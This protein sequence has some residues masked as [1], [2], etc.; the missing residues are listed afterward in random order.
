MKTPDRGC[1]LPGPRHVRP[2]VGQRGCL[3]FGRVCP[4]LVEVD[5]GSLRKGMEQ[6]VDDGNPVAGGRHTTDRRSACARRRWSDGRRGIARSPRSVGPFPTR[7]SPRDTSRGPRN[8]ITG[9]TV[10]TLAPLPP[11]PST[12]PLRG[13]FDVD[14]LQSWPSDQQFGVSPPLERL[15]THAAAPLRGHSHGDRYLAF[16][17]VA[18]PTIQVRR[19]SD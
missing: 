11:W 16:R 17:G 5:N 2:E 1:P 9:P 4:Q 6:A 19:A 18:S 13:R 3:L 12:R 7:P 14:R 8:R 15:A 10:I